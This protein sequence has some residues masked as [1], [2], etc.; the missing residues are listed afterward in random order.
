MR[1]E[2]FFPAEIKEKAA[3]GRVGGFKQIMERGGGQREKRGWLA[4]EGSGGGGGE[5][6]GG[7][8][9]QE[10][11]VTFLRHRQR[12]EVRGDANRKAII[13]IRLPPED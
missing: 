7:D 2:P 6:R 8:E 4:G 5:A 10:N 3:N 9:T 13:D 11:S 1:Y 12:A